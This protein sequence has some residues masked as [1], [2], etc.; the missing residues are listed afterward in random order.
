MLACKRTHISSTP[1]ILKYNDV[2]EVVGCSSPEWLFVFTGMNKY[3]IEGNT[4]MGVPIYTDK[5]YSLLAPEKRPERYIRIR[6]FEEEISDEKTKDDYLD[7]LFSSIRKLQAEVAR[8]RNSFK[9]GIVSYT[10]KNTAMSEIIDDDSIE[11]EP[12]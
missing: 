12:I 2:G 6:D 11:E 5:M 4:V 1:P 9:Y 10:N 8:L 3:Y 7:I